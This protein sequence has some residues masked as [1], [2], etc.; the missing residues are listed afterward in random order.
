MRESHG[1]SPDLEA[2]DYGP[3]ETQGE[4]VVA[5][6]DVVGA[7]VLQVHLLLLEELQGLVHVLQA[8]DTH[9]A[10]GGLGLGKGE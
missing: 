1:G 9:A 6:D 2:E 7:H 4:S 5:V 8:V 10:F 3:D